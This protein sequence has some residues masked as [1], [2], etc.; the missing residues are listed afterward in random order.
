MTADCH[1]ACELSPEPA[2]PG[3]AIVC[4]G[5]NAESSSAAAIALAERVLVESMR[6]VAGREKICIN[7]T[8]T[9]DDVAATYFDATRAAA[10]CKH[11][12]GADEGM[13][14][15]PLTA[16]V[17]GSWQIHQQRFVEQPSR[18]ACIELAGVNSKKM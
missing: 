14:I 9:F 16:A 1:H 12:P 7:K 8:V 2:H 6:W 17:D 18:E 10:A 11:R 13:A 3:R 15:A 5:A 4:A